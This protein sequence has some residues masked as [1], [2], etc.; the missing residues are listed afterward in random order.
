MEI[1]RNFV[2][3]RVRSTLAVSGVAA[4]ILALTLTGA[5]AEHFGAQVQGEVAYYRSN[6]QVAGDASGYAGVISLSKIDPI[7]RLPGVAAVLP[8]IIVL[9][10][11]GTTVNS[12][13]GLP[14]TIA[15]RDPRERSY[16]RLQT[17]LAAGRR[18]DPNR[19]GEVVLGAGLANEM[20]V[21]AGDDVELPVRPRSANPDFVSHTFKVV[22]VLRKTNT[23]P[24]A[25]ASVGLLDAQALLQE[26][27]PAVFRGRVDPSS[28]AS[29]ITVYGRPGVDLDRL[30]DRINADVPGVVAARPTD[31]V[32]SIDQSAGFTSIAAGAG[33]LAVVFGALVLV[34][35]LLMTVVERTREIALKM[36]FG[37]RAW[38]VA[39]EHVLEA[40]A[41][42]VAGGLV[43]LGAG[44]GLAGLLDLAGRSV[45][46]DVFLVTFRL[47]VIALGLAA[48][49]GAGA[50][51]APALR[52]A[53]LDPDPALRAP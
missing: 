17:A 20:K 32:R 29:A 24:D 49:L 3:H 1:V 37:A 31:Y 21:G 53:R 51:L 10:R 15:Y 4:G 23:L 30:A 28:L 26:S 16:S 12:P 34:S 46:M 8:S 9:A 19:R 18:L 7:Q 25:T 22:G 14:D 5:M 33:A 36:A 45:G 39:A 43:G 47:A 27:L 35:T 2:E 13:L 50:G 44:V 40:T 41:I 48:A 11:P 38:H 6:I 42:G 52:A